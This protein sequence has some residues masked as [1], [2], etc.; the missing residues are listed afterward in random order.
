M[1]QSQPKGRHVL[2]L[3]GQNRCLLS[4]KA[5]YTCSLLEDKS[6]RYTPFHVDF[7]IPFLLEKEIVLWTICNI[8]HIL[9]L[10]AYDGRNQ[11]SRNA[12]HGKSSQ[13]SQHLL[14]IND[15]L[16]QGADVSEWIFLHLV[17]LEG[18]LRD[19]LPCR[20]WMSARDWMFWLIGPIFAPKTMATHSLSRHATEISTQWC[21][22]LCSSRE[23][24]D[25][26][27][28]PNSAPVLLPTVWTSVQLAQNVPRY[29][30]L[31]KHQIKYLLLKFRLHLFISNCI[32]VCCTKLDV[33]SDWYGALCD[34]TL[35]LHQQQHRLLLTWPPL[36]SPASV[37]YSLD[38]NMSLLGIEECGVEGDRSALRKTTKKNSLWW[39]P[40][41]HLFIDQSADHRW[42]MGQSPNVLLKCHPVHRS[43]LTPNHYCKQ[44]SFRLSETYLERSFVDGIKGKKVVP[45][46]TSPSFIDAD[47]SVRGC[48]ED[49]FD[50]RLLARLKCTLGIVLCNVY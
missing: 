41:G 18:K 2:C 22:S 42:R 29:Q 47:R 15:N 43:T 9:Q 26:P 33:S 4:W 44:D 27:S 21:C 19:L 40:V 34:G 23:T 50:M 31:A 36:L 48:G 25:E 45:G 11:H 39:N 20:F 6:L 16:R 46:R 1:Y 13:F 8:L 24:Q 10:Q 30:K 17:F 12:R 14:L 28:D 32:V 37:V 35:W 38:M 5:V 3:L 7:V 49:I